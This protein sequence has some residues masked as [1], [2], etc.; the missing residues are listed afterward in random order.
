M[1]VCGYT[2]SHEGRRITVNCL[3]CIYG[4]SIEDFEECMAR[5]IDKIIEVK[6]VESIVLSQTRDFEYDYEQTQILAQIADLIVQLLRNDKI[7]SPIRMA[8]PENKADIAAR[9]AFV[10]NIVINKLRRDPI[11]AY[12]EIVREVRRIQSVAKSAS[13]IRAKDYE[14]YL[15]AALLP[16]KQGL[17]STKMVKFAMPYLAGYHVGDRTIYREIFHPLIR[18]NFMF[19]RYMMVPPMN[20]QEVDRYSVEDSEVQIFKVPGK[21]QYH[22]HLLPP[23]FT[24]TEEQYVVLDIA[25]QYMAAHKPTKEEF[26]DPG[27]IRDIFANIGRDMLVEISE[28]VGTPLD[29]KGLKF[30]SK[31]LTRYTAGYGILEVILADPATQDAYINSPVGA[32]PIFLFHE[33]YEECITNIVPTRDDAEAWAT[34]FRIESGRPLDES[35]P[36]LDTDISL[37]GGRAR[38]AAITKSV[39]PTGLAFAFRR[40]RDRPWTFPLLISKG[41][42][43]PLAAGLMSFVIDGARTIVYAGTRSAGKTSVLGATMVEIMKRFRIITIEDTLEL[44]VKSLKD[45][46]FNIE[47]LKSR[48][49]ITHVENEMPT[50]EVIRTS[51]RLGDSSLII[52]EIRSLEAKALYEAMR[53]GALSNVVAGTIHGESPY[54]VFDRVVNDLKVPPTSFKATDIIVIANRLKSA[55]GLHTFRRIMEITEVQKEW[56]KDPQKE[57]A[58]VPLMVYNS[59]KDMLE[60]TETLLNG[61][62][63]VINEIAGRVKEWRDNWE[64]V[65][66]NIQLRS[67][68]KE[69]LV[70]YSRKT[71]NPD[72]IEARFVA[73]AND[74]FHIIS[75]NVKEEYGKFDSER[76]FAL[77]NER[78]KSMIKQKKVE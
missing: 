21:V 34:R 11:G 55:D 23:E 42:M 62:S 29:Q 26:I 43:N 73:E 13:A 47:S 2:Y 35:S 64:A 78:I 52:G 16:I 3:G 32:S 6:E 44:P 59:K 33:K 57:K 39:S 9:F 37:P 14:H 15:S 48:S 71:G 54:G 74:M 51:L 27:R 66:D 69:T 60:P 1:N 70:D 36:V 25:R 8:L 20:A 67:K 41:M 49:V 24:L 76:I 46:G 53:I 4:A 12:V 75:E 40:H 61:E 5:T 58:F 22:Y 18:P 17:E 10:Q 28:S 56:S 77:W 45:L 65:W 72:I 30:L 7:L 19:T 38:V 50:D 68:V 63:F 31:I